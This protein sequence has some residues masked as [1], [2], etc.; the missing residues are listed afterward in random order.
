RTEDAYAT[1]G[2]RIERVLGRAAVRAFH[3]NDAK[4][5]LGSHLDRHENIGRGRIGTDGFAHLVRDPRWRD[6]PGY[7]ETPLSDDGYSAYAT[8]LA[9]L[10]KLEAPRSGGA[11]ATVGSGRPARAGRAVR[12]PK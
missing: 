3:L 9:T 7:L 4:A 6:V 10:R 11:P 5:D 12:T 8:D 1:L 2:D